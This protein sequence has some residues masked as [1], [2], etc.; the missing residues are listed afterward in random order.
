MDFFLSSDLSKSI[1]HKSL[2]K[3]RER[4]IK[5]MHKQNIIWYVKWTLKTS[6][7]LLQVKRDR[8]VLEKGKEK[9]SVNV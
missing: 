6:V 4:E 8:R 5:Q 2:K 9:L 1:I 3:K 7:S